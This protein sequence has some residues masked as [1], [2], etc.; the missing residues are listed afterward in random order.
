MAVHV[1]PVMFVKFRAF[2]EER[3]DPPAVCRKTDVTEI[4][5]HAQKER[6]PEDVR[7]FD[8]GQKKHLL[9]FK[10]TLPNTANIIRLKSQNYINLYRR[11]QSTQIHPR[12]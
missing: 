3:G 10:K 7:G 5:A 12:R 4:A 9:S 6:T 1:V 11:I 8:A 2:N